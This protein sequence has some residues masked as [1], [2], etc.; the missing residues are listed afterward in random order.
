MIAELA[1]SL[2]ESGE[3]AVRR[4]IGYGL[5]SAL[6]GSACGVF[7]ST[8]QI[9]GTVISDLGL[10]AVVFVC[11]T[12]ILL[13]FSGWPGS[14]GSL[15]PVFVLCANGLLYGACAR[16]WFY[17]GDRYPLLRFVLRIALLS[18]FALIVVWPS[19]SKWIP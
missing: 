18:W 10:S 14:W 7:F 12:W 13:Q 19:I 1:P 16:V 4:W 9:P 3:Q 17:S 5:L 6:F 11:P 2:P 8:V 15:V